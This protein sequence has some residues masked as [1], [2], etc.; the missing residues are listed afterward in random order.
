MVKSTSELKAMNLPVE[1]T[2]MD[3]SD[4]PIVPLPSVH[5]DWYPIFRLPTGVTGVGGVLI[6]VPEVGKE[7]IRLFP[8]SAMYSVSPLGEMAREEGHLTWLKFIKIG[9]NVG[10]LDA[11]EIFATVEVAKSLTNARKG[12][13]GCEITPT[14]VL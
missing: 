9:V 14:M 1:S 11:N 13:V 3:G 2:E 6:V 8:V 5:V 10:G 7:T 4:F 12:L